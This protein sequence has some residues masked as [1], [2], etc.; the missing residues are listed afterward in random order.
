[1]KPIRDIPERKHIEFFY[2][3]DN[4]PKVQRLLP[5][6]YQLNFSTAKHICESEIEKC[7][8]VL[9]VVSIMEKIKA[10]K[11]VFEQKIEMNS[12]KWSLDWTLGIIIKSKKKL[13]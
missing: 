4:F 10:N 3:L 6:H 2:G 9:Y 1:M 13:R 12:K 7:F 8:S 11:V 5:K